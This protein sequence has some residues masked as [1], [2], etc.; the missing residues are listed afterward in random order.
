MDDK[1]IE[2][3]KLPEDK[4]SLQEILKMV[5]EGIN[6]NDAIDV[7]SKTNLEKTRMLEETKKVNFKLQE[8]VN[9]INYKFWKIKFIKEFLVVLIIL[10]AI[11]YLSEND[12]IPADT[13]GTLLGSIIGYAVGNFG[14]SNNKEN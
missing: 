1:N 10:V 8:S 12:K 9:S 4:N 2:N 5:L 13:V 11:L 14:F 7:V 6:I 3:E